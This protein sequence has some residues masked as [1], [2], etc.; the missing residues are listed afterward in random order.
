MTRKSKPQQ[1]SRLLRLL[2]EGGVEFI[3]IGGVAAIVHGASRMTIDVD[4]AMPFTP[5]NLARLLDILRPHNPVHATR[6]E[7][8]LMHD[9]VEKISGFR[10]LW[11][12]T[13][14][15]GWTRCRRWLPWEA[16]RC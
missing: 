2:L 11:I 1:T 3:L 9:G 8:S 4:L 6:P 12:E 16:M 5:E 15:G 7:L 10:L 13:D 14:S